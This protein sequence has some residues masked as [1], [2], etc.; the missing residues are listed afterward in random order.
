MASEEVRY[1]L[2]DTGSVDSAFVSTKYARASGVLT[3][4]S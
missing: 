1:T 4:G 3:L 2:D